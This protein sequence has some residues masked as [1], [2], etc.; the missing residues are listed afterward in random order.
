ML[1]N[2]S[3]DCACSH[4]CYSFL[5]P[6]FRRVGCMH[7]VPDRIAWAY[8]GIRL[9]DLLRTSSLKK[10]KCASYLVQSY[11]LL[12]IHMP[13]THNWNKITQVLSFFFLTV[14]RIEPGLCTYETIALPLSYTPTN[15]IF[16]RCYSLFLI[17]CD[18]QNCELWTINST[19]HRWIRTFSL[20]NM[21][22]TRHSIKE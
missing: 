11:I 10:I 7:V 12:F 20:K 19:S 14:L 3:T 8:F 4:P 22:I 13:L 16:L 5:Y 17:L 18:F 2:H 21:E 6:K 15:S 1:G 9:G